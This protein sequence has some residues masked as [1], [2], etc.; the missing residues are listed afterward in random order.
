MTPNP[1][2]CWV[3]LLVLVLG[4]CPFA[5]AVPIIR[6]SNLQVK[7]LADGSYSILAGE[8]KNPVLTAEIGAEVDH[9]WV[10]SSEYPRHRISETGFHDSLGAGRLLKVTFTGLP[11]VPD[12]AYT[13][14]VYTRLP[15]GDIEAGLANSTG[16]TVTVQDLRLVEAVGQDKLDLGGPQTDDRVLSDS[17]SEDDPNLRI[18]DLGA[19]PG[20]VHRAVGT[21]LIYNRHS[22]KSL[23]LAALTSR[24]FLTMVHLLTQKDADG[25][26]Q[27]TTLTVDSTGTTEA[28]RAGPLD[29]APTADVVELSLPVPAGKSIFSERVM[30]AA[31]KHYHRQLEE[32][33]KTIRLLHHARIDSKA[34]TG[35][36]SWTAYYGNIDQTAALKNARWLTQHLKKSGFDY[37]HLD[38]G[39]DYARGEY[40]TPNRTKFPEGMSW[41]GKRVAAMGLKLGIWTAPFEVSTRSQVYEHHKDWLVR[42]AQ[43]QPLQI[44]GFRAGQDGTYIL[45]TTNPAAQKHL[46]ETYQ[47]IAHQWGARYIKL[48]FMETTAAEGRYYRPDTTALE[49]ECIGL[50]IIREAVGSDVLLDKDGSPMLVPVGIVDDGRI[51]VDTG[52][53]FWASQET[54]PGIAARY[55]MDRNFFVS[56]PDAFTVSR[57]SIYDHSWPDSTKP[58]TLSS[59]QVSIV[60]AA[61]AGGM[62]EIGDNLKVLGKDPDR[63]ALIENPDLLAMVQLGRAAVPLDLMSYRPQD[64]QPSI[65][66]LHEN[67][68]KSVLAVFNWTEAPR[69][70]AF[71]MTQ[72]GLPV[73]H[74][75]KA[76]DA[77]DNDAPIP[78][79]GGVLRIDNQPPHSVRLIKWIDTSVE[80]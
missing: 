17:Y 13:V 56:D 2:K 78:I 50:K 80:Y 71:K 72:L 6:G 28:E 21:Q 74:S 31:G 53:S 39:Y 5:S 49:A 35:W 12:L 37:F 77:L 18:Y 1:G 10:R 29:D 34:P 57:Q 51:S 32:Y 4:F 41:L 44:G 25:A 75:C 55:Y 8:N 76:F 64:Q 16:K 52:H 69:S 59:A 15:F 73:R 30:F 40:T 62:Y 61:L 43:D 33:G 70:H 26:F 63:V 67:P 22:A 65:F 19:A 68:R 58:L 54:A 46:R 79:Q 23:L 11:S 36:W 38:E 27:I 14:R 66:L 7:V 47:T 42:N 3:F 24:R 48:D 60:L 20:G 45:D 9:S